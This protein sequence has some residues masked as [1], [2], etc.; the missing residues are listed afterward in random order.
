M[1]DNQVDM[2]RPAGNLDSSDG[3]LGGAVYISDTAE[4]EE[5]R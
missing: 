2:P 1:Y 3:L 5:I 4:Y